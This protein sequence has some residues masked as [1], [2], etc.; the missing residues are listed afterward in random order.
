[1]KPA[2]RPEERRRGPVHTRVLVAGCV[3][4]ALVAL[5]AAVFANASLV[6]VARAPSAVQPAAAVQAAD[7]SRSMAASPQ[8]AAAEVVFPPGE[9]SARIDEMDEDSLMKALHA[10]DESDPER[11]LIVAR[12]GNRRFPAS[13][14]A[15]ERAAIIVKSLARQGKLSEA[16]AEAEVMVNRYAGTPWATEVEMH[17]GAHPHVDRVAR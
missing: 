1:V 8:G 11:A 4:G 5:A 7:S 10:L 15:A 12:E 17:T 16:R 9:G 6:P 3:G 2:H 14:A 13:A